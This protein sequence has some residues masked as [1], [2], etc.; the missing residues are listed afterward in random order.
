MAA[1]HVD[2]RQATHAHRE[3]AIDMRSFVVGTP[4]SRDSTHPLEHARSGRGAIEAENAVNAAHRFYAALSRVAGRAA[5]TREL[6]RNAS[7]INSV[8]IGVA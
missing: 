1:D 3:R 5:P 4:V 6:R 8:Q 2:D 7:N